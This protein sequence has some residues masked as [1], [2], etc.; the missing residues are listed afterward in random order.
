MTPKEALERAKAWATHY[1]GTWEERGE[2]GLCDWTDKDDEAL[3][4]LRGCVEE[5]ERARRIIG[6]LIE[7]S[8]VPGDE[9]WQDAK[10]FLALKEPR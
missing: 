7:W 10:A 3:R 8:E 9:H 4:V 5:R 6:T 1:K 2:D